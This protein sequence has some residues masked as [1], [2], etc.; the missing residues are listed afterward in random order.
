MTASDDEE[1][2]PPDDEESAYLALSRRAKRARLSIAIPTLLLG[3][4]A[5][6]GGYQ[7]AWTLVHELLPMYWLAGIVSGVAFI[8]PVV[9]AAFLARSL[10]RGLV[11]ARVPSWIDDTAKK[12]RV[13]PSL[14]EDMVKLWK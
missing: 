2:A 6:V 11:R 8:L 9:G 4:A 10:G 14:L 7:L 3:F 5:G 1:T 13:A 12:F